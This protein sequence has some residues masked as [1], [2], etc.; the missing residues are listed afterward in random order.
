[1]GGRLEAGAQG[2]VRVRAAGG[3]VERD[4]RVLLVHR[5]KYDDWTFPKGKCDEGE[6]DEAC[7]L[8][9]VWEETG[10]RCELGDEVGRTEY[11]DGKGRPKVVRWWR[12][13]PLG[14]EFVPGEEVDEVRWETRDGAAALLSYAHDLELLE[15]V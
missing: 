9:E 8:R 1:M 4:G 6:A 2:G 14:G 15:D 3:I 5:P 11:V 7:A 13:T 10:L 12:M